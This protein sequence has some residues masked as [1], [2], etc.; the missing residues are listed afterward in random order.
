M[1]ML[2]DF[3]DYIDNASIRDHLRA[4]VDPDRRTVTSLLDT[5]GPIRAA[6]KGTYV[7]KNK[8][9]R[10]DRF[11]VIPENSGKFIPKYCRVGS[12]PVKISV[13]LCERVI[14]VFGFVV[15]LMDK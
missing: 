5:T 1:I 15:L 6:G 11:I 8:W 10:M 7:Y 14:Y 2:G 3:N 12:T 13:N 4:V 9:H